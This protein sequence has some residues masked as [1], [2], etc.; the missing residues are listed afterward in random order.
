MEEVMKKFRQ[1]LEEE[2]KGHS[3][4]DFNLKV[5]RSGV[6][7]DYLWKDIQTKKT[8]KTN[9]VFAVVQNNDNNHKH[10]VVIGKNPFKDGFAI[11]CG[12]KVLSKSFGLHDKCIYWKN[13][14]CK[15]TQYVAGL[16]LEELNLDED[17]TSALHENLMDFCKFFAETPSQAKK[18]S[19]VD[20]VR[21][22]LETGLPALVVGPT[23]SGKTY[24]VLREL[25][26]QKKA[27]TLDF[28]IITFT[29]GMEDVDL[30]AK[31][32]PDGS[33]KWTI[34]DGEL[35]KAFKQAQASETKY[36]ILLE[37]LTRATPKALNVLVKAMDG[38]ATNY[39]LQNFI[40][41]EE[42]SVAKSKLQF[43]ATANLGSS[44]TGTSELDPAVMRRFLICRF[45]DY[46]VS[47][48]RQILNS[49]VK[50][51]EEVDKVQKLVSSLRNAYR[52]AELPY[53]VDTGTLKTMVEVK[54][55][56][57]LSY[58]EAFRMTALFRIVE[59]DASGYPDASQVKAVKEMFKFVGLE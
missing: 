28:S 17:S 59:K 32:I 2:T 30:L 53:P 3:T 52:Q 6:Q 18:S 24:A 31:I 27:G 15:H 35:W 34:R 44:Y 56:L 33:G 58:W 47:L 13:K 5:I 12:D 11:W 36:V 1:F 25:V 26:E 40:T 55:K 45:W 42:I 9:I 29:S 10:V 4:D 20:E 46:D 54:Q 49:I 37:E 41:G 23:G 19:R 39:H 8:A 7:A 48:E 38:V 21:L 16:C 43:I 14:T 22:V 51:S 50:N 57:K